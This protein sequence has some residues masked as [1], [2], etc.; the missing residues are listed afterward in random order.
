MLIPSTNTSIRNKT[1][2]TQ[3][4]TTCSVMVNDV[5]VLINL[6]SWKSKKL[7]YR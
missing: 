4:D 7:L 6:I 5:Y 3:F 2:V 1:L